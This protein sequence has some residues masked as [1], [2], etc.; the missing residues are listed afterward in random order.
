MKRVPKV[1]V[2]PNSAMALSLI[3]MASVS[4]EKSREKYLPSFRVMP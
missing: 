3:T 2:I 1:S 4:D